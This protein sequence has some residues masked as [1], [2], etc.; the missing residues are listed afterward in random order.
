MQPLLK[1]AIV[2]FVVFMANSVFAQ[3]EKVFVEGTLVDFKS[4][5]VVFRNTIYN[6]FDPTSYQETVSVSI[7]GTGKWW[8][9]VGSGDL[10]SA[11]SNATVMSLDFSTDSIGLVIEVD[12][13]GGFQVIA[14][15]NFTY[16]P[17]AYYAKVIDQS[18][19]FWDLQ[20][21]DSIGLSLH[22]VL[23]FGPVKWEVNNFTVGYALN[24]SGSSYSDSSSL[25]F[26]YL[27][28]FQDSV[29]S[30]LW[31]DTSSFAYLS[32]SS[33]YSSLSTN[34][35]TSAYAV[36]DASWKRGGN[37]VIGLSNWIGPSSDNSFKIKTNGTSRIIIDSSTIALGSVTSMVPNLYGEIEGVKFSGPRDLGTYPSYGGVNHFSFIHDK[38]TTNL[39]GCHDSL[40]SPIKMGYNNFT[41]GSNIL[42]EADYSFA[43][44]ENIRI[45]NPPSPILGHYSFAIGK[46][47]VVAGRYGLVAGRGCEIGYIRNIAMGD[48]CSAGPGYACVALGKKCNADGNSSPCVAIGAH[49]DNTGKYTNAFGWKIK[50]N[51]RQGSFVYADYSTQDTLQILAVT[52]N[53]NRWHVRAVGGVGIYSSSD[54]STGVYLFSG[55]GSWSTTSS[56]DSKNILSDELVVLDKLALLDIYSW[57]YKNHKTTHIGPM[58]QD[59]MSIFGYGETSKMINSL[60]MDGLV[61]SG[62]RQLDE[63]ISVEIEKL[64]KDLNIPTSIVLGEF[65]IK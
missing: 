2:C 47:H 15:A 54:L 42:A 28:S 25:V 59:M 13:G 53:Y 45:E 29:L 38:A 17:M 46:D 10:T 26:S 57:R 48:S 56:K 7:D 41:L 24:A 18:I 58:A 9:S 16:V 52:D 19:N 65:E 11:S 34:A 12:T 32:S 20:D 60:D 43:V 1:I 21:V 37:A 36:A 22:D 61:L 27:T 51:K 64:S 4:Q 49:I 30:S 23:L 14:D 50:L 3:N 8:L 40:I 31:A 35:D 5:T 55:S 44:G 33:D 6:F 39:G 63:E 62:I